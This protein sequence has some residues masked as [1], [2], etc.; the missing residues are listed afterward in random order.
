MRGNDESAVVLRLVKAR[1][2]GSIVYLVVVGAGETGRSLVKLA[3]ADGHDVV[4]IEVDERKASE[5]S[6]EYDCLVLH[7]DATT[8]G[9]LRDAGIDEA[10][11]VI[12]TTNV[13]AVN[14][15]VMLLAQEHGVPNLLSVVHQPAHL[16]VFEKIGVNV[17]ENPQRLIA[18]SL[19]H[20][21]Q[22]P[23]VLDF[24]ELADGTEL[25]EL[26]V[27]P[28]APVTGRTLADAKATGALPANCLVVAV[29]RNGELH[30]PDGTTVLAAGDDVTVLVSNAYIEET[31]D[32]FSAD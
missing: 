18:E 31:I 16:P 7:A 13:D 32:A 26:V 24:V 19:Y 25:I 15:M 29:K 27:D 5:V 2:E 22:Y 3:V 21:V 8:E 20:S 11:A 14:V 17:I 1:V 30:P 10:D 6:A 9:T 28:S 23:D 12:S 4:A